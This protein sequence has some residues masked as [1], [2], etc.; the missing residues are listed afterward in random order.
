MERTKPPPLTVPDTIQYDIID[1]RFDNLKNLKQ[2]DKLEIKMDYDVN[3]IVYHFLPKNSN[4]KLVIYHQGHNGDFIHG[5]DTIKFFLENGY[6]VLAFS[7]PLMGLNNQ[8]NFEI[9]GYGILPLHSHEQF[10]Y[11]DSES[12]SSIKFFVEP[13]FISLN[14]I[15]NH[16][17]YSNFYMVGISGGGWTTILYSAIDT[18]VSESYSVA[19]S[20]PIYLRT[21]PKNAG[22]YEQILPELYIVANYLDLYVL[23][24]Y[25]ENRKLIQIFNKY[26]T[27]C[28]STELVYEYETPIKQTLNKLGMGEFE[29]YFDESHYDH[30]ISNNSL[31]LIKQEIENE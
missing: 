22:D 6:S 19:G 24:A 13:I 1:Q 28:F 17:S 7:M 16:Y 27:C 9:P 2:I 30:I 8:P 29:I 12:F 23:N 14:Y 21:I 3:S 15:Q 31:E 5:I 25:G 18:R 26:D 4:E 10:K 11:I 20:V